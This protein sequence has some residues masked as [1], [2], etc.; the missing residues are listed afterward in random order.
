MSEKRRTGKDIWKKTKAF[1]RGFIDVM[2][3]TY[4]MRSLVMAVPVVLGS[5]WL[6]LVNTIR[7][8]SEVGLL[9]QTNGQFQFVVEKGIAVILPLTLTALCLMLMFTSKKVLFPWLISMLS[10]VLPIVIWISNCFPV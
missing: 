4:G 2:A 6:A 10:L 9:M 8:P 1:V 7:L 3:M 5:V